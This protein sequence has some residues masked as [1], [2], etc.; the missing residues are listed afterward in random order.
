MSPAHELQDVEN[1]GRAPSLPALGAQLDEVAA[2]FERAGAFGLLAL[3]V[4]ELAPIERDYG[5]DARRAVFG[6]LAELAAKLGVEQLDI[7]DLVL[8]GE[9]GLDEI[10]VIVFR[11]A[12][13]GRF[14]RD[15]LPA[16]ERAFR[17][18]L[19]ARG[20]RVLYPY[21]RSEPQLASG[22]GVAVRNPKLGID[23][24]LR[25]AL[26][27]AHDDLDLNV[28]SE[29]R[30]RRRRMLDV[31]LDRRVTSVYEPIVAV[32]SKTVF[33]YEALARGPQGTELHSP[34]AM[35]RTAEEEGLVFELDCLCRAS[36]LKGA[37]GLPEGT[38]LFLNIRPT[39]IHDP[40]FRAERLIRT[41]DECALSP[42]DVVFEVSEQESIA[43]F[44]AFKEIRDY[45]RDLGFQFALDDTGA[46][47]AGLEALV[48]IS[49]EF[50][51][52]DRSFVSGIDQDPTRRTL[53]AALQD[54]CSGSNARII[55]EGLDTLEELETL[56][57]LGIAFGQGWL[58]GK[59]TPLRATDDATRS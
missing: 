57:E 11:E 59:P 20:G 16:Y 53:L 38:K 47:Y 30:A 4:P 42:S 12:E 8:A 35:F 58:F 26:A 18:E 48:E 33:G 34:L 55:A 2:R 17:R 1:A 45:Y 39:T 7:E 21:G 49:P 37:V 3:R 31:V 5:V 56:G 54:V 46:G 9:P 36:G 10:V 14:L 51:K 27:E 6:R 19:A 25:R 22:I 29:A 32:E 50:V 15:E 24:Q 41:L 40:N 28:R 44:E 13:S 23:T 43:N 52:V